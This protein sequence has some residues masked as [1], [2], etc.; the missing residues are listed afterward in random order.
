MDSNIDVVKTKGLICT[1]GF[2]Y[3]K[4]RFSHDMAHIC[5]YVLNI[6]LFIYF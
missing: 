1:F 3:A 4:S 5:L 2:A 6:S